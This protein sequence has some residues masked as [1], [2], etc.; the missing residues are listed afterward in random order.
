MANLFYARCST[1]GQNESRQLEYAKELGIEERFIFIDKASGKNTDRPALQ[2]M[3]KTM[4][5]GD[6]IYISELSRLGRNLRDLLDLVDR[7]EKEGV[8]LHSEKEQLSTASPSGRLIFHVFASVSEFQRDLILENAEAG[9][10][11]A[12]AA[13]KHM[14]RPKTNTDALNHALLM[15]EH[16]ADK[17]I[18]EICETTKVSRSV[19]YREASKRNIARATRA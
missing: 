10:R 17:S 1:A 16:D 4:R 7:F 2:E 19:L 13:G 3:L 15:F 18:S 8:E 5:E 9:R 12:K 6:H 11:A 14:G